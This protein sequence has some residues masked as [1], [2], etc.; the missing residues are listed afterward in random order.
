MR[1]AAAKGKTCLFLVHRRELVTQARDRLLAQGVETG[2]IKAGFPEDR[3]KPVQVASIQTLH[4]RAKPPADLVF[5]DE[6]AHAVAGSWKEVL[7]H[8]DESTIIGLTATPY[9]LDGRGLGEVFGSIV[10]GATT[11]ELI[12]EGV[13][14]EPT[15]YSWDSPDLSGV[16]SSGD[17]VAK[18]LALVMNKPKLVGDIVGHWERL[19]RGR[20]VVFAVNVDHS[21]EIVA[22]LCA[23]GHPAEHLDGTLGAADRDAVLSRLASGETRVVS[24]C[25][26]LGEGWDLPALETA[27]LAR[28]TKSLALH[29]QQI[30]RIMRRAEGKTGAVVIDHAGNTE[31]HGL[32]SEEPT[33]TLHGKVKRSGESLPPFKR[34][35]QCYLIN[36]LAA[37]KCVCGYLFV[38]EDIPKPKPGKLTKVEKRAME[39][40]FYRGVV[41]TA[42]LRGYRMGWCRQRYREK[43]GK[44]PRLRDIEDEYVCPGHDVSVRNFGPKRVVSC[45][46]C[47]RS[48]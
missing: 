24:N 45:T 44:W 41:K 30:G 17:Y 25:M 3:D 34:C 14:I 16:A 39:R 47:L 26:V 1:E 23:A 43:Y 46:R 8:Y 20:G 48:L 32:V 9:R 27:I 28:P 15:T 13:L 42:S 10:V 12:D 29:R 37:T 36:A 40:E 5:V 35:P 21:K 38:A 11:Q 33:Y 31:R 19:G 2:I 22:Q 18:S 4:N 6:C 7:R